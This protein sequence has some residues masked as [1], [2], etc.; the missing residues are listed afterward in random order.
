[1]RRPWQVWTVFAICLGVVVAAMGWVSLTALRL[2]RAEARAKLDA[3][4]REDVRLALWR[5]DSALGSFLAGEMARPYFA[6][7]ALRSARQGTPNTADDAAN[8]DALMASELLTGASPYVLLHFQFDPDGRLTSPQVP[9]GAIRDLMNSLGSATPEVLDAA[10][11]RLHDFGRLAD[12]DVLTRQLPPPAASPAVPALLA[13][14]DETNP[15]PRG[16][17]E[18]LGTAPNDS[19]PRNLGQSRRT[20]RGQVGE[21]ERQARF[22]NMEQAI[23]LNQMMVRSPQ[24]ANNVRDGLFQAVWIDA[25]LVLARRV[26]VNGR[27]Y[28][29]G[30]WLDWP[31]LRTWLLSSIEDL[32]LNA[33]LVPASAMP[34]GDDENLLAA[35]PVRLMPGDVPAAPAAVDAPTRLSLWIAWGGLVLASG[36]VMAMLV[37]AV[38]LSERRAAFV[39]AVTHELRTPLTTFRMYTEMLAEGMV[40]DAD[41]RERYLARLHSEADRLGHLVENVLS[42]ARLERGRAGGDL[43]TVTPRDLLERMQTQLAARARQAGMELVV[44]PEPDA[45]GKPLRID[46]SAVERIVYNL[47]DNAC[48][49]AARADDQRIHLQVNCVASDVR[50]LVRDHGPGISASEARRLF[51]PFGK[52]SKQAAN[53]GPG[54]GLGLALSRRLARSMGG[55]LRLDPEHDAGACFVLSVPVAAT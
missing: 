12:A 17:M 50:F 44:E 47:V 3:A 31:A 45:L 7:T 18:D 26:D 55:D 20:K 23:A 29:Q 14:V 34:E 37:A 2:G 4:F 25:A 1:M 43:E 42:Y 35:L 36:A 49:Y 38:T 54:V 15:L 27:P 5:M 32:A 51:R 6:Y 13:R 9:T 10:R 11:S 52:S 19:A 39:S 22:G 21:V 41:K 8:D 16:L 48:K 24:A 33:D 53:S 28:I 40:T 30:C 46:A